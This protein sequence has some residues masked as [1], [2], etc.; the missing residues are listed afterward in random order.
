MPR[1]KKFSR[2]RKEPVKRKR[3]PKFNIRTTSY[4]KEREAKNE[5][6]ENRRKVLEEY[7]TKQQMYYNDT[8]SEEEED[9]MN[10]LLKTFSD[11]KTSKTVSVMS[12]S[13]SSDDEEVEEGLTKH[14]LM[15]ENEQGE[16]WKDEIN[17]EG[18]LDDEDLDSDDV[19]E[20]LDGKVVVENFDAKNGNVNN[21]LSKRKTKE[22][23]EI[24]IEVPE[25]NEEDD[26]TAR[27]DAGHVRDPFTIHFRNDLDPELYQTLTTVPISLKSGTLKWS[28][29]GNAVYQI[30]QVKSKLDEPIAKKIKTTLLDNKCYAEYGKVPQV[31]KKIDLN[32]LYVKSSIQGNITRANDE[33][34]K[35]DLDTDP[36]PLSPLQKELFSIINNY[37]DLLY[38]E[39][40][41]VNESQIRFI[42]CLHVV[43][44]I[45][46]NRTKILHHNA[47]IQKAKLT[48]MGEIPEEYR[49]QGLVRPKV[50]ILVPFRH[51]CLKIVEILISIFIGEDKGGSVINK[52]RFMEDYGGSKI[53]MPKK[54]PK[55]EDYEQTF[56]GN[57]DDTFKIGIS[58][59][60]KALKLYS[61]FYSSD[62]II[63]SVLGLRMT[64]GAEGEEERD[65]DFLA[66]IEL[67]IMD[68][69]EIF[70]MQNWD[71]LLH[72]LEHM[73]LQPKNSH[74]IDFGRVRSWCVNG[75]S[76]YYRQTLIFS[77]IHLPE[78]HGI[79]NKKCF[80]YAGKVK[81]VNPTLV[82]SAA[83][84]I[85]Q[86]PQV[87]HRFN[88]NDYSKAIDI[89]F[90]FFITKILPQYRD[91]IMNHTLIFVPSYFDYV[92]LRNY[93]RK[94]ELSFVQICEY[95]KP[96]KVARARDMF[97]HSDAHCLL[98]TERFHFYHR[99]RIK[100]IRHII[101][102]A[103]PAFS[104]FYSEMCNL[105]QEAYQNPKSGS[106][107]NMTVTIIYCKYD[108]LPLS[109]IVGSERASKMV[110]SEKTVHMIMT[111]K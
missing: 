83:Q 17:S 20:N 96:A 43:N 19:D 81:V 82:G 50:L 7:K 73:H 105:L 28:V 93:F 80:N 99:I 23:E 104:H 13:E 51:S 15:D 48:D 76:K 36:K 84:V 87:F 90:E 14:K 35:D 68:Q 26:E 86:I 2:S 77:N 89:R 71:H 40:T 65:Y 10:D 101:F 92:K 98:Y 52:K 11:N 3:K 47:K 108:I 59:T 24:E 94:E 6:I 91:S 29:L 12:E 18:E 44:H 27:E 54:N 1:G 61:D 106:A 5:E 62:I 25:N 67:L 63:S 109:A 110:N 46:K 74:G 42:Y 41:F 21:K 45:L 4:I 56:Q 37:Q 100:G 88:V 31:I 8:S 33:N 69:M 58:I 95:S 49:D 9:P 107:S 79:F 57:T 85:L 22:E 70:F 75:W 38:A 78:I 64:I 111:E 34:I 30:P 53:I 72:I 102:Y 66:S 39:K 97:F 16:A 32:E 55:P 103:P 60:K